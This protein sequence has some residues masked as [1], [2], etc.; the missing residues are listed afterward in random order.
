M[1]M[2]DTVYLKIK[3][4]AGFEQYEQSAYQTKDIDEPSMGEFIVQSDGT[5]IER[6]YDYRELTEQER[7]QWIEKYPPD[8]FM[9]QLAPIITRAGTFTDVEVKDLHQDITI[10][11]YEADFHIDVV[12]R[13]TNGL[14]QT[15][16]AKKYPP[17]EY[18]TPIETASYEF[19]HPEINI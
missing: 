13:Y 9:R 15:V 6:Q 5:L 11:R 17:K 16:T 19:Q 4:P 7:Q 8:S 18:V 14:L 1:G 2:F 10:Y 12:L 3:L